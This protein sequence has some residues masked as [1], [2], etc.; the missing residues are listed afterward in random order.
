VVILETEYLWKLAKY[1]VLYACD[2]WMKTKSFTVLETVIL[3]NLTKELGIG[4]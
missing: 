3:S 4:K 1:N 2:G